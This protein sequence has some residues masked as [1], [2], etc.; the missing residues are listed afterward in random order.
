MRERIVSLILASLIVTPI[1]SASANEIHGNLV[2]SGTAELSG[3]TDISMNAEIAFVA[4]ASLDFNLFANRAEVCYHKQTYLNVAG[5][6]VQDQSPQLHCEDRT[7]VTITAGSRSAS[8]YIAV[9]GTDGMQAETHGVSV[10][11]RANET[12]T[13]QNQE[14]DTFT[15]QESSEDDAFFHRTIGH[16]HILARANSVTIDGM[17]SVKIRGPVVH[18]I[19]SENSTTFET[20]VSK[21]NGLLPEASFAWIIIHPRD[22]RSVVNSTSGVMVAGRTLDGFVEGSL[23][24]TALSGALSAGGATYSP[25]PGA[26]DWLTGSWKLRSTPQGTANL[27]EVRGTLE[28]T[29]MTVK[30]LSLPTPSFGISPLAVIAA[31]IVIGAAMA[32][33]TRTQ[34]ARTP[35][36]RPE[37]CAEIAREALSMED[38]PEAAQWLEIARHAA[39]ASLEILSMS[40][41]AH[42]GIGDREGAIELQKLIVD[43]VQD[44]EQL[45]FLAGLYARANRVDEAAATLVDALAQDPAKAYDLTYLEEFD[46]VVE[47][48]EVRRAV[49]EA[50]RI[51]G[52]LH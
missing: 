11:W 23:Q 26:T 35:R 28:S 6:R 48:P 50:R 22:G 34:P 47:R 25:R 42:E 5:S 7:N 44:G 16:S 12:S 36:I 20:G 27:L 2:L 1:S 51:I 39:P 37:H 9:E 38:Y 4:G 30:R 41:E 33:A 32:R 31:A 19:S 15:P 8:G 17:R 46:P 40:V 52:D 45:F 24:L 29:T 21:E 13:F 49:E 10:S 18:V 14:S 43:R 3:S